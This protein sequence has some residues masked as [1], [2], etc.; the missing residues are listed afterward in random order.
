MA[1]TFKNGFIKN[2]TT[3]TQDLFVVS[4]STGAVGIVLSVLVANVNGTG[5]ADVTVTKVSNTGTDQS[6]LVHTVPVPA[7]TSLEIVANKVVLTEGEKLT[8]SASAADY[9][10]AT[11]SVL[12]IV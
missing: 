8:I 1:S 11:V 4:T 10:D 3:G 7:D 12:E 6:K 5:S 9:L 2:V